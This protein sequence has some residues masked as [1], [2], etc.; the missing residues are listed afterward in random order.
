MAQWVCLS[1]QSC[2]P[3][4]ESQAYRLG[5][6]LLC[7]ICL[8]M[9]KRMNKKRKIFKK[10]AKPGPHFVYFRPFLNTMTNT[11]HLTV[12]SVDGVLG[13]RTLDRK[14]VGADESTEL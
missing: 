5:L 7:Y 6:D 8:C 3:R 12:K 9:V 13:I 10:W 2:C 14:M 1:G 4:F 11:I